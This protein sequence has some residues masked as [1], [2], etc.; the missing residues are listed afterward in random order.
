MSTS[1][2]KEKA[3]SFRKAKDYESALIIY[4]ELWKQSKSF[5]IGYFI[6]LCLRQTNAL[7]D[8]REFHEELN[9]LF[10]N[11]R[12]LEIE[13]L[14]LDYKQYVK[15]YR[16]DNFL[17]DAEKIL[18]K[19]DQ[20]SN[21]TSKIFIKTVLAVVRRLDGS[22]EIKLEWLKKLDHSILDNNVFRIDNMAYPADRKRY[23]IEYARVLVELRNFRQYIADQMSKLGFFGDKHSEFF[24]S[25]V[26]S[27]TYKNYDNTNYIS[28]TKLALVV[29]NL[30]EEFHLR[31]KQKV[32]FIYNRDKKLSVSDL[33]HYLFC[34]A[35]YAIGRTYKIY[36][37]ESWQANEWK[38]EKLYLIDRQNIFLRTRNFS[39]AFEDTDIQF[40]E[41]CKNKFLAIF[42]SEV[43]LNN[44]TT[45]EAKFM[46]SMDKSLNGAPD[47][48]YKHPKGFRF[49]VTEKFSH[50]KSADFDN[51]F[52]SDLIKHYAFLDRFGNYG[53]H[54]GLFL[55]WYYAYKDVP[56]GNDGDKQLVIEGYRL[57]KIKLEPKNVD[58]LNKTIQ[59]IRDFDRLKSKPVD[60]NRLS[61]EK[62]CL[63]CSVISYCHHKTGR[64]NTISLPYKIQ[65]L[66]V[67]LDNVN[68]AQDDLPF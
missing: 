50:I 64:H 27:F 10:P 12:Q 52:E 20:Y 8:C 9:K 35:S 66:V 16:N 46:S 58:L 67:D 62:K 19:T 65:P 61:H 57:K 11:T 32:E 24:K 37:Q 18:R 47:Y 36:F 34:P 23:F 13:C 40:T 29:K 1:G 5:W 45:K 43:E 31:E 60:G 42:E 63:N 30:A 33:S 26:D 17:E 25:L 41:E 3:D 48:I 38:R 44:V 21:D 54:F 55:T 39:V 53:L 2:T 28:I 15:D 56:N 49:V 6:A 7:E 4:L 22:H 51:P 68:P 14:W 59:E